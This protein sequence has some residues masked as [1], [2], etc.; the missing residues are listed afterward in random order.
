MSAPT[1]ARVPA[2]VSTGGQFSMSARA[3]SGVD[4]SAPAPAA[5]PPKL[6][7]T[8]R[9]ALRALGET[10]HQWPAGRGRYSVSNDSSSRYSA[11]TLEA[12]VEA[13]AARYVTGGHGVMPFYESTLTAQHDADAATWTV[14]APD[15]VA[16][17]AYVAAI[18][19]GKRKRAERSLYYEPEALTITRGESAG[20]TTTFDVKVAGEIP[21]SPE[22]RSARL[23]GYQAALP[24][25]RG[26]RQTGWIQT[27]SSGY[28]YG[29]E[30]A[31]PHL[32]GAQASF[33]SLVDRLREAGVDVVEE[34]AGARGGV[35]WRIAGVTDR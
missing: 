17:D 30:F 7:A 35:G 2:G 26:D 4:L 3:E 1:Q 14:T 9:D 21:S 27:M 24:H 5:A 34:P 10:D 33:V 29:R 12:L 13:G 32:A 31:H 22:A 18:I 20:G 25:A 16:D 6:T 8:Q 11:R 28:V 23:A 19:H 15:E